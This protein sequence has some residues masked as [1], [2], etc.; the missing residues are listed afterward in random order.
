MTFPA[1]QPVVSGQSYSV[2]KDTPFS[3]WVLRPLDSPEPMRERGVAAQPAATAPTDRSEEPNKPAVDNGAH[4]ANAPT[5][6]NL[7]H[8]KRKATTMTTT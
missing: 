2:T 4:T 5:T 3:V 1:D 8:Q 6:S 7:H